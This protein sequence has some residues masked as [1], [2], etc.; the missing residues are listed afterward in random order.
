[1]PHLPPE[2]E[3]S[4][5]NEAK[6]LK[7][8]DKNTPEKDHEKVKKIIFSFFLLKNK[9]GGQVG[10]LRDEKSKWPSYLVNKT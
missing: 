4:G 1:M 2:K 10:S 9:T 5:I 8:S 3:T 7:I 6:K